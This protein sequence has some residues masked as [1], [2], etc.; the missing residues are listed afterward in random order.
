[1]GENRFVFLWL[2]DVRYD[3]A[4]RKFSGVFFEVPPELQKWHQVGQRLAFDG[5]EIFDWMMLTENG[6]LFGGYTLRVTR[7]TLPE[8]QRADYDRYG[9]FW[10]D[11]HAVRSIPAAATSHPTW[12]Y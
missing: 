4:K 10:P 8:S 3:A 9:G 7:G 11:H 12:A 5:D 6:H 2:S 1:L